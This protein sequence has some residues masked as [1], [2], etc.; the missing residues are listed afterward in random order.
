MC[1]D[2]SNSTLRY[3]FDTSSLLVPVTTLQKEV[4]SAY[5]HKD[6]RS[7]NNNID[8]NN[9]DN[10]YNNN[11]NPN[12]NLNE[13]QDGNDEEITNN[14][15]AIHTPFNTPLCSAPSMQSSCSVASDS[16]VA[17]SDFEE[18]DQSKS[19]PPSYSRCFTPINSNLVKENVLN[20]DKTDESS[21]RYSRTTADD[22]Q[23]DASMS[24]QER[25]EAEEIDSQM[26]LT[27][28]TISQN[29]IS[30]K[31]KEKEKEKGRRGTIDCSSVS[32]V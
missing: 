6:G 26:S 14:D 25:A 3:F 28:R 15:I 24:A 23:E 8:N 30:D 20:D 7:H 11:L 19:C 31:E 13:N 4:S 5:K 16:N 22:S 27:K 18:Y 10:N 9:I 21:K 1:T 12:L 17:S 2:R 32:I 29:E